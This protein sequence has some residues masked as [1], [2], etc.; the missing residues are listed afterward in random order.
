MKKYVVAVTDNLWFYQLKTSNDLNEINFWTPTPWNPRQLTKGDKWFFLLK[1]PIRKIAGYGHFVRYEELTL[2]QAWD[3]YKTSNG[4]RD[5]ESMRNRIENY[6]SKN[7]IRKYNKIG[8]IIL[9]QNEFWDKG[10]N[11]SKKDFS[12]NIVT[13]KYFTGNTLNL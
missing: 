3:K 10:V 13:F 8:C 11:I 4:C 7:S 5:I 1:A 9:N 2:D 12:P 6:K